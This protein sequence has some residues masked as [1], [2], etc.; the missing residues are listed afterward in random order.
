MPYTRAG[1]WRWVRLPKVPA[2]PQSDLLYWPLDGGNS[3]YSFGGLLWIDEE[4]KAQTRAAIKS[5]QTFPTVTLI[6]TTY[7]QK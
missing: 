2:T 1:A 6:D 3:G 4:A 5:G 7:Q